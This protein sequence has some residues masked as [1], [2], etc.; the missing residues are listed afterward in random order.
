MSDIN[1]DE[2][3]QAMDLVADKMK[4][5]ELTKQELAKAFLEEGEVYNLHIAI[6]RAKTA[7]E[8]M[9]GGMIEL[10]KQLC[11]IKVFEGHGNFMA[12]CEK[13]DITK[14][15]A[16]YAMAA[17]KKFA[18]FQTFGNLTSSK[19]QVLTV[20]DDNNIKKLED[21]GEIA[22]I[23]TLDDVEKMTV[24]ELKEA[25][26]AERQR[27]KDEQEAR[28]KDR[29]NQEKAIAQK[30]VKLNQL[31]TQLRYQEPPTKEQLAK[32]ELEPITKE[33][34][35]QLNM[36][37][38]HLANATEQLDAAM[39]IKEITKDI[40]DDEIINRYQGELELIVNRFDEYSKVIENLYPV[41]N[42]A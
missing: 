34:F 1:Q 30:E 8:Q 5:Q 37:S 35:R 26:R 15:S 16:C 23:G 13:L 14:S 28:K 39:R 3:T 19:I 21:G 4:E 36:V 40:L 33:L 22:G 25:I 12:S 41:K 2:G 31:E 17:A 27:V 7:Q 6:S 18:N 10:G 29:E 9:A 42:E 11:L 38:Y 24:R 32:A 20:L